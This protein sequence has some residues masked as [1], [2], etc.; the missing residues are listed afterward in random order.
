MKKVFISNGRK[1]WAERDDKQEGEG[2]PKN[3]FFNQN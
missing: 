1:E 3:T 2:R